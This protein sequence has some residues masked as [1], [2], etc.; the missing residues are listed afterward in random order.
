[1]QT[2]DFSVGVE[3]EYQ[4]IDA[5]TRALVSRIESVLPKARSI[6]EGDAEPELYQSQIEVG[7]PICRT[8]AD[9]RAHISR[10]RR[11]VITAAKEDGCVVAAGGTHPF[12]CW[13]D[14]KV[15]RKERYRR[16]R[17]Q[18]QQL[19]RE[20]VSFG[21]H[22][23]V[24]F[25]DREAAIQTMNRA[26][27]R[28]GPLIALGANSPFWLGADSGFASFGRELCRRWPVA[29]VPPVFESRKAHDELIDTLIAL[30]AI[31]DAT[32]VYWDIRPSAR[33]D[34]L[35]FRGMDV[36]TTVD[37]AV[38]IAGLVRAL[39]KSCHAQWTRG[40]PVAEIHAEVLSCANWVASRDGLDAELI[41]PETVRSLP[42]RE[43]IDELLNFVRPALEEQ[44]SWD[45]V[46]RFVDEALERGS[47]AVRQRA[48]FER[49][50]RLEDVVDH[51]VKETAEQ[52]A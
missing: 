6:G 46:S 40:E 12:S 5:D 21:C 25:S 37:E 16:L 45:E 35:E 29:G 27:T 23:H 4:I 8:L 42:A 31:G 18:Y 47:G 22:I 48:V 52:L 44:E 36:C 26:R 10:L 17:D 19:A 20:Q 1:M 43:M 32:K 38:M 41:D 13:E 14:Q 3:E 7:T 11:D 51:V 39:A 30:K 15:T 2:E 24:G 34:T 50:G 49:S 33:F 9:V 28:L